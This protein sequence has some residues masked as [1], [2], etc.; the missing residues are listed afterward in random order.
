MPSP[1]AAGGATFD[2]MVDPTPYVAAWKADALARDA[3]ERRAAD[4][5]IA[6]L[7]EVASVLRAEFGVKRV[8]YFGSLTRGRLGENSDVDVFVDQ[9][10]KGTWIG[11]VDRLWTLLGRAVDLVEYESAPESLRAT[12]DREGILIGA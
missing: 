5:A 11:A 6:K 10:R 2:T 12:I 8:G 1:W 7:D 3:L 9:I 4:A